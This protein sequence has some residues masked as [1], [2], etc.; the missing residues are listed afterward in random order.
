MQEEVARQQAQVIGPGTQ[1]AQVPTPQQQQQQQP[2]SHTAAPLHMMQSNPLTPPLTPQFRG[3]SPQM[4]PNARPASAIGN[5]QQ[6]QQQ[7]IRHPG[8]PLPGLPGMDQMQRFPGLPPT[9][10]GNS[11]AMTQQ[12]NIMQQSAQQQSPQ[13]QPGML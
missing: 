5:P 7:Q 1:M 8:L 9:R 3:A 10:P 4:S 2:P 6:Q 11:S 12:M 13:T